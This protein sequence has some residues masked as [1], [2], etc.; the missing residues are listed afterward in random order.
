MCVIRVEYIQFSK[1]FKGQ[2]FAVLAMVVCT[3]SL[4]TFDVIPMILSEATGRNV[5]SL[6]V[7]SM[8]FVCYQ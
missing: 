6:Y 1:L 7:I 4:K 8:S 2:E 3:I 5:H